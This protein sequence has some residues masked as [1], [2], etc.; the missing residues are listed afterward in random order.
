VRVS[1]VSWPDRGQGI[2]GTENRSKWRQ[3]PA[4]RRTRSRRGR[5]SDSQK[6]T[7]GLIRPAGRDW[8][9]QL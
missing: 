3:S 2:V 5:F 9:E 4:T 1:R 8:Q 6:I 7:H